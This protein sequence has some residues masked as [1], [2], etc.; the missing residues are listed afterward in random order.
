MKKQLQKV[1]PCSWLCAK[2]GI[3]KY[4]VLIESYDFKRE[5]LICKFN[6]F[7][8]KDNKVHITFGNSR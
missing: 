8:N 7:Q 6:I 1:F 5:G 2:E 4:G 3:E